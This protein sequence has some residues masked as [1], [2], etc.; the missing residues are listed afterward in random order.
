MGHTPLCRID[1]HEVLHR[2]G[3]E[4]VNHAQHVN[5]LCVGLNVC[6]IMISRVCAGFV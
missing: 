1:I 3:V 4:G 2:L 5:R 6:L